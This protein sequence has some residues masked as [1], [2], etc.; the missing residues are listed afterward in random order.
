MMLHQSVYLP[1]GE[2]HLVEWMTKSGEMVDGRGTYQ[3]KKLR[4]AVAYCKDFRT[5]VDVGAH[6]GMWTMQ[7]AKQFD[8]VLAFEPVLAHQECFIANL[9]G[10]HGVHLMP[11]ALG[12]HDG[13]VEMETAP[14]SSGDTR[15]RAEVKSGG[16]PLLKLDDAIEEYRIKV[17]PVDFIKLDC[18]GYELNAL[19]GAAATIKRCL[20][21]IIVEQKPGRAQRFG[22]PETGAVDWLQDNFGYR[23]AKEMSGDFIMVPDAGRV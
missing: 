14:T 18:E 11:Y 5:A 20:P 6:C 19:K 13:M 2:K 9:Y 15:V 7:L 21:V 1:D 4:A 22:L 23:L 3:I 12:D 10:K 8:N 16:V 17:G